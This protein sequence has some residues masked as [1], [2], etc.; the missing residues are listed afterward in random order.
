MMALSCSQKKLLLFVLAFAC[1]SSSG[2][3]AWSWSWS[4]GSGW[5]WGSDGSSSSSSGPGSNSYGSSRSWGSS[6][7]WGWSWGSDGSDNSG[8]APNSSGTE[9]EA[10][11]SSS[12][13][14]NIVVGGSDGWKK[15]LDYKEWASNNA[16]F[17]VNDVLV[18]KLDK[19]AKRR[20]NVYLF[21]D[22]W[23]Y[24]NCDFKN[25]KKIGLTHKRSGKSFKFTLRKNKPYFFASGEHDGDY[26]T[27][28][29]MKFT[30]FPVPLPHH[31][32]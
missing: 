21:Q 8:S 7:G 1:L 17:Y 19:T 18:F 10:P 32:D 20:N 16:P 24:M 2:A 3:E 11:S 26:C 4:N 30:L 5:G 14:R 31:S 9:I 23:S 6:P 13:P 27:N 25:A 29:N 28:H 12:S 15:G 22:P